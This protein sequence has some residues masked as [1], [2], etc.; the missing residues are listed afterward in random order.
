MT[1]RG[2]KLDRLKRRSSEIATR[3]TLYLRPKVR[4][5]IGI[6]LIIGGI[7]GFLPI[8]GFWMIPLGVSLI[9]ADIRYFRRAGKP[10]SE[11]PSHPGDRS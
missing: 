10:R 4:S 9:V 5:V 3:S 1:A 8:L 6:L 7:L 2:S 11:T